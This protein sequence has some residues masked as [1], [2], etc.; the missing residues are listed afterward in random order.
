MARPNCE[1][2]GEEARRFLT[3]MIDITFLILIFFM[4]GCTFRP[5]DWKLKSQLPKDEGLAP[6]PAVA[7][8]LPAT[9]RLEPAGEDGSG[10]AIR[11]GLRPV[12]S[13]A[14]LR[15]HLGAF[16]S[17][18]EKKKTLPVVLYGADRVRWRWVVEAMDT[19]LDVGCQKVR[20]GVTSDQY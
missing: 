20:F 12:A 14:E 17:T 15:A 3:P 18:K 7:E 4:V 8:V 1:A 10:C 9:V 2:P 19:A 11:F 5:L 16:F 13:F 6:A